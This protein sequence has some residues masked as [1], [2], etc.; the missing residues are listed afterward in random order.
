MKLKDSF[1]FTSIIGVTLSVHGLV[2]V[3]T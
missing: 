3:G 2:A 1:K